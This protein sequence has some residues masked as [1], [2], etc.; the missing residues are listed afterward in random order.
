MNK[1]L[2]ILTPT[3]LCGKRLELYKKQ[4]KICPVCGK[5]ILFEKSVLDHQHKMLK[6]DELGVNG[7]GQIR[8]VLCFQCNSWEG[9][10]FNSLRRY[11][12]H[13][14]NVPMSVLLRNL[15]DYLEREKLPFIHPK[16]IKKKILSKSNYNKLKK[17][18][19]QEGNIKKFPDYPKSKK[20][21]K[22][23]KNLFEQFKIDPYNGK[24]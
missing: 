7:T 13:K 21:T 1:N 14:K 24:K 18:Y 16:E 10:I 9:K 5:K 20:I 6:T 8:G 2:R 11:G 4:N 19:T 22:T 23:L 17:A 12:L 15:A 3:E